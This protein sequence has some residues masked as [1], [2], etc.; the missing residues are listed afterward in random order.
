MISKKYTF[1]NVGNQASF[2][3]NI[4]TSVDVANAGVDYG[5]TID[6]YV[7][8]DDGEL[9]LH[10]TGA[11]GNQNL[12]YS[13]KMRVPNSGVS[14]IHLCGQTGFDNGQNYDAQPGK[15]TLNAAG[16]GAE[17]NGTANNNPA[18]YV[19]SPV[20]KQIVFVNKQFIMVL[21]KQ[22]IILASPPGTVYP[23]WCRFFIG[24]MDSL[25]PTTETLLN[26]VDETTWG[27]LGWTSSMFT[28]GHKHLPYY[29][30]GWPTQPKPTTGLLWKQPYD[31]SPVNKELYWAS[32]TWTNPTRWY[33]TIPHGD[34]YCWY[35]PTSFYSR[36]VHNS[37][38]WRTCGGFYYDST[39]Y[40][41]SVVKHFLHRPVCYLYEYRDASNIFTHPFAYIPYQAV[42]MGNLLKGDDVISYG[43]RNFSVY[44]DIRDGNAFGCALEFIEG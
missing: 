38:Y 29:S 2:L 37:N 30:G 3:G 11:Y 6:R 15:F 12:Y 21:W 26:W 16:L 42:R 24:A 8:G 9:L 1:I 22:D 35:G 17:W 44:P 20:S 40:N 31:A 39:R 7:S 19:K 36:D 33:S 18:N 5:W 14:H 25:F 34:N 28:G 41:V 13:V 27:R 4:K 32:E 23:A 10:S 43:T